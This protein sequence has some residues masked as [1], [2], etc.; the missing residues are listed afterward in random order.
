MEIETEGRRTLIQPKW[1]RYNLQEN[2]ISSSTGK[3]TP[4]VTDTLHK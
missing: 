2:L 1:N 4:R 3:E